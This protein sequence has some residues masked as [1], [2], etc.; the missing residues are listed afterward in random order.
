[1]E[2]PNCIHESFMA[3]V[4]VG[5]LSKVEGG[6]ITSYIAEV[7]VKCD[8]CG[9][10]FRFICPDVGILPDRPGISPD[11][12]ELRVYIEPS[13]GTLADSVRPGYRIENP[14]RPSSN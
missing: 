3:N 9:Q 8:D 10:E 1:M 5:R 11:G 7:K 6:E 14:H 2:K 13:D 4:E 12:K